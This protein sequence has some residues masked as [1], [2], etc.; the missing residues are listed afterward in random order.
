MFKRYRR[1]LVKVLHL[2]VVIAFSLHIL[3]YAVLSALII[4]NVVDAVQSSDV[5]FD[6]DHL[7]IWNLSTMMVL[8]LSPFYMLSFAMV[9]ETAEIFGFLEDTHSDGKD[10]ARDED[11][12]SSTKPPLLEKP[13]LEED[14][15]QGITDNLE[16]N[17]F[18]EVVHDQGAIDS[19]PPR[20][21]RQRLRYV[22]DIFFNV[23]MGFLIVS[24]TYLEVFI[25]G[26]AACFLCD[27]GKKEGLKEWLGPEA[28]DGL[29]TVFLVIFF[30]E[31]VEALDDVSPESLGALMLAPYF[32]AIAESGGDDDDDH[33]NELLFIIPACAAV[34]CV[35]IF[36]LDTRVAVCG[37][38]LPGGRLL[39]LPAN[40]FC[41]L[42]CIALYPSFAVAGAAVL[43]VLHLLG[44]VKGDDGAG[45]C[46]ILSRLLVPLE[47]NVI[48]RTHEMLAHE[49][50]GNHWVRRRWRWSFSFLCGIALAIA[51]VTICLDP[52]S[53]LLGVLYHY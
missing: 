29:N 17:N 30:L 19:N 46:S 6:D 23:N 12:I 38:H 28:N 3:E 11:A 24:M 42:L 31:F 25:L 4:S 8:F 53:R 9:L 20:T 14:Y 1:H 27:D 45:I 52:D 41:S 5:W 16:E 26:V 49:G 39:Y 40:L 13:L 10:D 35:P 22:N 37:R 36:I 7:S 51:G 47:K 44:F 50:G 32:T 15:G 21:I 34:V 2:P 18:L 48:T 43:S 33:V